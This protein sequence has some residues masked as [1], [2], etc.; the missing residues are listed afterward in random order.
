MLILFIGYTYYQL[1]GRK[2]EKQKAKVS[3]PTLA[4]SMIQSKIKKLGILIN[5]KQK[6][7]EYDFKQSIIFEFLVV[8]ISAIGIYFGAKYTVDF[9]VII[10][11]LLR[12]PQMII[13]F[14]VIAL[15]TSLPELSVTISSARKGLGDI[16][17]GNVIGSNIANM[18]LVGGAS[19][20]IA[21]LAI[22]NLTTL[23]AMLFVTALLFIFMRT[24]WKLEIFD[25]LVFLV[26]Y[27]FFMG[28]VVLRSFGIGL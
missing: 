6:R 22:S 3:L 13:G 2:K 26:F 25:G 7:N 18:L 5:D 10:A 21:P 17:A 15:G 14:T 8:A 20:I 11:N 4:Y 24:R 16:V 28:W 19:A 9:A 23:Y 1:G 12:V 27:V